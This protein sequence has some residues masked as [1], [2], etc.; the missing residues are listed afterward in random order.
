MSP[1]FLIFLKNQCYDQIFAKTSSS[2]S[3]KCHFYQSF[4]LWKIY[5]IILSIITSVPE[6]KFSSKN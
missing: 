3:Q 2:L 6:K 5:F 1:I 4:H